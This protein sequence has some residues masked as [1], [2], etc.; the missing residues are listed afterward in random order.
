MKNRY[1]LR[2]L[3][4]ASAPGQMPVD[5]LANALSDLTLS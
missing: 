4:Q 1:L 2:V 3:G 5:N